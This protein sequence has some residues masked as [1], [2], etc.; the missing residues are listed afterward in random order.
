M[1]WQIGQ[2]KLLVNTS[3]G[4]YPSKRLE[5]NTSKGIGLVFTNNVAENIKVLRIVG[6]VKDSAKDIY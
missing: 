5:D 4:S 3:A 6:D 2:Q 1:I